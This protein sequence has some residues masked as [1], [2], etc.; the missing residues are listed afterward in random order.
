M[1]VEYKPVPAVYKCFEVIDL[2]ARTQ[3]PLGISAIAAALG[4]HRSTVFNMV[5][6]LA[7]LDILERSEDGKF[8]LGNRF[9]ELGKTANSHAGLIHTTRPF[10]E[11]INTKTGLTAFLGVRSA[12]HAVVVD[13][14]D[15][16]TGLKVSTEIGNS[17]S[18]FAGA[19]GKAL[20]SQLTDTELDELFR[21]C[22][23]TAYTP[24][25]CIDKTEYKLTIQKVRI[26]GI[27]YDMEEYVEGIRALAVPLPVTKNIPTAIWAVGLKRM[28]PDDRIKP[29]T[30]LLK[31]IAGKI[32]MKMAY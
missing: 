16:A 7:D 1:S 5:Y 10:L 4:F 25:T 8:N 13:K 26:E 27:A 20:L 19:G 18:L 23:L 2:F 29:F 12:L 24:N 31:G 6:S 11:E 28:L 9:Y 22:D 30:Q 32:Y 3:K 14:A 15:V 21:S 17:H